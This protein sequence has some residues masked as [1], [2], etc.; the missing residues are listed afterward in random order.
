MSISFKQTVVQFVQNQILTETQKKELTKEIVKF[1]LQIHGQQRSAVLRKYAFAHSCLEET[2]FFKQQYL[3]VSAYIHRELW[4][5]VKSR[6]TTEDV[7]FCLD[8]LTRKELETF[9]R[10]AY[11]DIDISSFDLN[12]WLKEKMKHLKNKSYKLKFIRDSDPCFDIEDF[13]QD[14]ALEAVRVVNSFGRVKAKGNPE[15]SLQTQLEKY[16]EGSLNNKINSLIEY[17]TTG[18][19]RRSVNTNEG[20]YKKLKEVKSELNVIK[21]KH[22]AYEENVVETRLRTLDW[23]TGTAIPFVTKATLKLFKFPK[24]VLEKLGDLAVVTRERLR[25]ALLSCPLVGDDVVSYEK[26]LRLIQND[27]EN[28]D[29]DYIPRTTELDA[30]AE[31][32]ETVDPDDVI[33]LKEF[34]GKVGNEAD[35][36]YVKLVL[37]EAEPELINSFETWVANRPGKYRKLKNYTNLFKLARKYVI[38]KNKGWKLKNLQSKLKRAVVNDPQNQNIFRR[39]A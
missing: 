17:H 4:R 31:T 35:E 8:H 14:L 19:R 1:A 29:S 18:V 5:D 16:L 25:E 11:H 30:E 9:D 6:S 39:R 7:R 36:A 24:E 20:L 13:T 38:E 32:A 21:T 26:K 37:G 12:K 10:I 34:K 2:S 22:R 27:I 23:F 15:E 3:D 33:W 28:T